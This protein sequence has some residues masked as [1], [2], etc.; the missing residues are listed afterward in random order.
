MWMAA[1]VAG[2]LRPEYDRRQTSRHWP[3]APGRTATEPPQL[4]LVGRP[5][6]FGA[7]TTLQPASDATLA[8]PRPERKSM[9]WKCPEAEAGAEI[10]GTTWPGVSVAVNRY[11]TALTFVRA[12]AVAAL[13]ATPV[14]MTASTAARGASERK[15]FEGVLISSS[16]PQSHGVRA[17][18][19]G[20][21]GD[22]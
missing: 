20:L 10:A 14:A 18:S 12:P 15:R 22:R 16:R 8:A 3:A 6:R 21:P 7:T 1:P 4:I 13:R 2:P 9:P 11:A 17:S 5:L 19:Q